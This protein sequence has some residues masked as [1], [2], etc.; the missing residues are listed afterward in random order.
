MRNETAKVKIT[1]IAA[2]QSQQ[3]NFEISTKE[4]KKNAH[5]NFEI[6]WMKFSWFLFCFERAYQFGLL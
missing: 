2:M 1:T 5:D 3:K 4:R 6:F